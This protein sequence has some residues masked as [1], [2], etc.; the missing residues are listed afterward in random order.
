M[1]PADRIVESTADHHGAVD[2]DSH[3]NADAD[4]PARLRN[5]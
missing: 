4:M 5:R 2:R 3:R 1:I